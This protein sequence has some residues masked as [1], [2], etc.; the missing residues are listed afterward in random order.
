VLREWCEAGSTATAYIDPGA[1]WQNAWVESLNARFHDEVLDV[2]EF[3]N[4]AEARILA[5]D[6]QHDYNLEHPHSALGMMSPSRFAASWQ[7]IAGTN[8]SV[9]PEL[10]Q[11]I[12]LTPADWTT[13]DETPASPK[14]SIS[15]SNTRRS[16]VSGSSRWRGRGR[17][18]RS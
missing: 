1:P 18:F 4:L 9:D 16:F 2:E 12:D 14:E 8:G 6:W 5:A 15:Q 3:T 17:P 13:M 11:G 7:R 10:S